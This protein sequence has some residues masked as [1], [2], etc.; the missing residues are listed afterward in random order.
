MKNILNMK[1]KLINSILT[2]IIIAM[3]MQTTFAAELSNVFDVRA[4]DSSYTASQ[5]SDITLPYM[6]M[7]AGKIVL[8]KNVNKS[9]VNMSTDKIEVT[10]KFTGIHT[11][12]STTE[13][14]VNGE[15]EYAV[16]VAPKVVVSGTVTKGLVIFAK[17]IDINESAK[18]NELVVKASNTNMNGAIAENFLGSS[19]K[20]DLKGTVGKDLRIDLQRV[21]LVANKVAGSILINTYNPALTVKYAY[22]EA[23]VNVL[24]SNVKLTKIE[25]REKIVDE[26]KA[27]LVA[28]LSF[29][30]LF[31][32]VRSLIK[33]KAFKAAVNNVKNHAI[34]TAIMGL[35]GMLLIPV[36]LAII[37]FFISVGITNIGVTALAIYLAAVV[38]LY[39]LSPY[40]VGTIIFGMIRK[41]IIVTERKELVKDTVIALVIY[42][43]IY[44]LTRIPVAGTVFTVAYMIAAI[45][46]LITICIKGIEAKKSK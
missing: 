9:G 33:P 18:I 15:L 12:F 6:R 7:M 36:D 2:I 11:F 32:L 3:S 21:D 39:F 40:I 19:T 38:A 31:L 23:K 28:V 41:Y 34:F 25:L 46:S 45:G 35:L 8:D 44:A 27:A 29:G 43:V 24:A 26:T 16:I 22:P 20:L 30:L 42:G 14:I 13:V 10:S 4:E 5:S 37:I 1:T 17:D